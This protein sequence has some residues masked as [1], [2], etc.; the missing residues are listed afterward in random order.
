MIMSVPIQTDRAKSLEE[1]LKEAE[2]AILETYRAF[3]E[4]FADKN[5]DILIKLESGTKMEKSAKNRI[6][7]ME[8][9]NGIDRAFHSLI[10]DSNNNLP[11]P[12]NTY[13]QC[14]AFADE[15]KEMLP[16]R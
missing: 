3:P 6:I 11:Y 8:V 2:R 10:L 5:V 12:A 4:R 13:G 7:E 14:E 16:L 1:H 9:L 15:L